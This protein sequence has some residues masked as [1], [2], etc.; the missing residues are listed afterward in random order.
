MGTIF[1]F[2][3]PKSVSK[4]KTPKPHPT[5]NLP[6]VQFY[7]PRGNTHYDGD[8]RTVKLIE[9]N[10][11][12]LKGLEVMADGKHQF[13]CFRRDRIT[14]PGPSLISFQPKSYALSKLDKP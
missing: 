6:V 3:H 2:F 13:K 8:P 12:H 7:Y 9:A 5:D 14:G 11:T 1:V 4:P 10:K